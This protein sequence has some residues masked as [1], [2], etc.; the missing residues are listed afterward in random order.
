MRRVISPGDRYSR[1]TVMEEAEPYRPPG[2][3]CH[4]NWRCVCDCGQIK[5]IRQSD[6]RSR[7]TESCTCL[8]IEVLVARAPHGYTR[9]G[10]HRS[11]HRIWCGML[12]R[13]Y[14]PKATGFCY[15]GG[16]GIRV[17]ERWHSFQNF[18][19]DIG[20][21]PSN[22]H[23]LDR[24]N[25]A[26]N[27]EPGNCRWATRSQQRRNSTGNF[28][29]VTVD[30]VTRC[31]TDWALDAGLKPN[32]LFGR[33]RKGWDAKKAVTTPRLHDNYA[34]RIPASAL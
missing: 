16:R 13:C 26:G 12:T 11:E 18:I 28:H 24:I 30:G 6:L 32:T 4:A 9:M 17:C 7:R 22:G 8:L 29:M 34:K 10:N 25:N 21:R 2:G 5:V 15:Y 27:Y 31:A 1:L 3:Q 14:N 33:L 19:R 20:D 23:S